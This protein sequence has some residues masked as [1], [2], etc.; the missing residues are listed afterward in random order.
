M[1]WLSSLS[2]LFFSFTYHTII[3][4]VVA[5]SRDEEDSHTNEI[6]VS[7][8]RQRISI[9]TKVTVTFKIKNQTSIVMIFDATTTSDC[10]LWCRPSEDKEEWKRPLREFLLIFNSHREWMLNQHAWMGEKMSI[11][12]QQPP[13]EIT[14][15]WLWNRI[16]IWCVCIWW[17]E[18]MHWWDTAD[19]HQTSSWPNDRVEKC[20]MKCALLD[21]G[22]EKWSPTDD[23]WLMINWTAPAY[24]SPLCLQHEMCN[25]VHWIFQSLSLTV[26]I[27]SVRR[28]HRHIA[29]LRRV[30]E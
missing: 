9:F 10:W 21:D 6:E 3:V 5:R 22:K 20:G 28:S 29:E 14:T 19:H 12:M 30:R 2:P 4:C 26:H 13:I 15:R 18:A 8:P 7:R 17:C 25:K 27:G 23:K 1:C 16:L 24:R 11:G